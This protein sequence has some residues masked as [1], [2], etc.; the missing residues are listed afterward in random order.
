MVVVVLVVMEVILAVVVVVVKVDG[1]FVGGDLPST[2]LI[3][4]RKQTPWPLV[5]KRTI[6]NEQTS[7][8]DEI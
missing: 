3:E 6:P 2:Q 5:S 1:G 4:I 7:L 8:V